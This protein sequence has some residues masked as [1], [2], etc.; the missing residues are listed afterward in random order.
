MVV[1]E[2]DEYLSFYELQHWTSIHESNRIVHKNLE[3]FVQSFVPKK[4]KGLVTIVHGYLDHSGS[5]SKLIDSLLSE[6]YGIVTFDLPGHGHSFGERGDIKDFNDYSAAFHAV[7][8]H[9]KKQGLNDSKWS[10]IG[11]STGAAI[12]LDY[13]NSERM[14]FDKTIMVAPLVQPYLWSFSKIG[15]KIIGKK[16]KHIKK[17]HSVKTLRIWTISNSLKMIP[18]S[19]PYC[20]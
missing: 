20:Q 4:R 16:V 17:G 7:Q 19:F 5:F 13:I 18:F 6:G 2:K 15:V 3:I 1:F 8:T 11:H 10:V 12:I 9:F 14:S